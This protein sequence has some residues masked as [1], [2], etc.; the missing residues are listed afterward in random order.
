MNIKSMFCNSM[1]AEFVI[2]MCALSCWVVTT[3][4]DILHTAPVE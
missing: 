3:V 2:G 1:V 4:N